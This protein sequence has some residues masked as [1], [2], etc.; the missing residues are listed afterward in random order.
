MSEQIEKEAVYKDRDE[1]RIV[2]LELLRVIINRRMMIVKI[3]SC[4]IILSVIYSLRLNNIYTASS[5]ILPPPREYGIGGGGAGAGPAFGA[6]ALMNA[7]L[8]LYV[9]I[10]KSRTV[11][12]AVIKRHDL[13]RVNKAK[14]IEATRRM[15]RGS[16][17]FKPGKDGTITVSANSRDP[18]MAAQLANAFVDEM[19]RRS[20]QLYLTR[21]GTERSFL[22]K[23]MVDVRKELD[24]AEDT[25]KEFQEKHKTLRADGQASVAVEGI[26]RLRLE[27]ISKEVQLA[28]LRNTMTD[29]S[30]EVKTLQAT[31]AK[32]KGQLAM[33]SGSGG[34]NTVI[35]A[36]G[37]VP[38]IM[39]EYHRLARDVRTLDMVYEQ[40][41]KQYELAKVNESRDSAAIQVIDEAIPPV[42]K[43]RPHRSR[44][45][46]AAAMAS[47]I[48]AIVVVLVQEYLSKLSARDREMIGKIRNALYFWKREK[49]SG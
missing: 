4:A 29:E 16:V 40:L 37:N 18:Q 32:L 22:E 19:S 31:I 48:I 43:S 11:L 45:I 8:E 42:Q 26:A 20:S 49:T 47:F 7:Y 38:A 46:M 35:P 6:A 30:S 14:N 17:S 5:I 10:F 13:Q 28:T 2:W 34:P 33:M 39:S 24:R 3:C 12:D 15:V 36:A 27:I 23:R 25:L 1:D 44:I 9:T 21:A 41:S